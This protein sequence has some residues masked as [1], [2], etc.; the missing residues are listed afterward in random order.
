VTGKNPQTAILATF[1]IVAQGWARI[2]G[3]SPVSM[4]LRSIHVHPCLLSGYL[5]LYK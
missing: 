3:Y 1:S 5:V 2:D 4:R